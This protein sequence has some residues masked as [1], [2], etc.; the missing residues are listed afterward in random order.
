MYFQVKLLG[1]SDYADL[2]LAER[3]SSGCSVYHWAVLGWLLFERVPARW[4]P[5]FVLKDGILAPASL[6]LFSSGLATG[7]CS[8]SRVLQCKLKLLLALECVHVLD[9]SGAGYHWRGWC[10]LLCFSG[11]APRKG[12]SLTCLQLKEQ[13]FSFL[14]QK[15][16]I[17]G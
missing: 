13:H 3:L 17:P 2:L 5:M 14:P 16:P 10:R 11:P 12:A 9:L 15:N 1:A 8:F 4:V 7:K 6:R